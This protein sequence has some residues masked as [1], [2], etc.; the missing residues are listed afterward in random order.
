MQIKAIVHDI[1]KGEDIRDHGLIGEG[2]AL[3]FGTYPLVNIWSTSI[4]GCERD[5][6]L[7][8]S[9]LYCMDNSLWKL[10]IMM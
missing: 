9:N 4:R 5:I 8:T 3:G 6:W 10:L 7:F 2:V 1:W